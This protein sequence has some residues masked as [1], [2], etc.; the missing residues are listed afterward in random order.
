MDETMLT[1]KKRLNV[2]AKK[3]RLPLVPEQVKLP[4]M[5]GCVIISASYHVFD[6]LIILPNKKTLRTLT[7][8]T[9]QAYFCSSSAGWMTRELFTYYSL[10][11][12]CQISYYRL[13]LPKDIRDKRF[14]LMVEGHKSRMNF[15][16]ASIFY[17]FN[18][19]FLLIP[20]HTSHLIQVFVVAIGSP[21]KTFLKK[22]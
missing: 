1:A 3:V 4:H 19:D 14:L 17:L 13:M 8:Y 21:L 10:L 20:P 7:N 16:A 9:S 11:L 12:V 2:L 6:P 15:R 5:T 18:I 22:R